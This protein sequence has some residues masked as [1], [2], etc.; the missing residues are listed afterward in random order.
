[1][2][3][4]LDFCRFLACNFFFF[5]NFL[6]HFYLLINII[7][8]CV[9]IKSLLSVFPMF[10]FLDF[11]RFLAC[12]FFFF[13]NLFFCFFFLLRLLFL[14]HLNMLSFN[15]N[16]IHTFKFFFNFLLCCNLSLHLLCTQP[17]VPRIGL[18]LSPSW[19]ICKFALGFQCSHFLSKI[20]CTC[21]RTLDKVLVTVFNILFFRLNLW[22]TWL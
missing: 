3:L 7:I 19:Y 12:N 1:M 8:S 6:L 14:F 5:I 9:K 4:F 17:Q 2:F 13:I 22:R 20:I 21:N 15:M 18:G 16:S 11:C 10:L